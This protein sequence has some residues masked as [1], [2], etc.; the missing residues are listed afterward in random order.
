MDVI[1]FLIMAGLGIALTFFSHKADSPVM[2]MFG[3]ILLIL[4]GLSTLFDG[5]EVPM[6]SLTI[7]ETGNFTTETV[8]QE[9]TNGLIDA[10]ALGLPVLLLGLY[11]VYAAALKLYK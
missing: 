8:E 2:A 4:A 9:I 5:V 10:A 11:I 6:V 7:N 1:L 3:G